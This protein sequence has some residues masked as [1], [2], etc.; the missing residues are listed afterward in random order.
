VV[1]DSQDDKFQPYLDGKKCVFCGT[2]DP[3]RTKRE[4]FKCRTCGRQKAGNILERELFIIANF[5][6]K[7]PA[8]RVARENAVNYRTVRRVYRR[9]REAIYEACEKEGSRRFRNVRIDHAYL[10]EKQLDGRRKSPSGKRLAVCILERRGKVYTKVVHSLSA[11]KCLGILRKHGAHRGV[12]CTSSF[13]SYEW[14]HRYKKRRG[15]WSY[16]SRSDIID[17]FWWFARLGFGEYR[18]VKGHDF[19]LFVKEMECRFNHQKDNLLENL[20]ELYFR[21]TPS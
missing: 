15:D 18:S 16:T 5:R 3:W 11:L 21:R 1:N 9:L 12:Y 14:L 10:I 4:Y 2:P 17:E 8:N 19:Y 20:I 7:V 13:Y 6:N